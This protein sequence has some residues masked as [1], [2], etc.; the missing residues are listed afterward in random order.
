MGWSVL[1]HEC[2]ISKSSTSAPCFVGVVGAAAAA[3]AEHSRRR[4]QDKLM[5]RIERMEQISAVANGNHDV[6]SGSDVN[7]Q[8][9]ERADEHRQ[10]NRDVPNRANVDFREPVGWEPV[11]WEPVGREPEREPM[12]R[13]PDRGLEGNTVNFDIHDNESDKMYGDSPDHRRKGGGDENHRVME[14][15][16][17]SA[18]V[19][20]FA[21]LASVTIIRRMR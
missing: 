3:T 16:F 21:V 18:A 10:R 2:E 17:V 14:I 1:P 20:V 15:G 11:G 9:R 4:E 13:E 8:E 6:M 19:V 12:G 5:Q 7:I